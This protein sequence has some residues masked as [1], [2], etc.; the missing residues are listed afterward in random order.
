[1]ALR[2]A[3]YAQRVYDELEATGVL[4]RGMPRPPIFPLVIY[5]GPGTWNIA[6]TLDNFIAAPKP[7]PTATARPEDTADARRAARDLAAF[8]LR[9]AYFTL[10]FGLYREDDPVADNAVSVHIGLD[11]AST[12]D[13]VVRLLN[14][15]P[16]LV[17][18]RLMQT[19]L[20]W[21]L[22]RL[23]MDQ[24]IAEEIMGM[25]NYYS[26]L[27][28]TA[29]AG[30]SS[31]SPKASNT[32]ALK[33]NARCCAGRRSG[34]SARWRRRSILSL[35]RCIPPPSWRRSASGSWQ[36]PSTS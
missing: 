26:Q 34:G 22:L 28:E 24:D 19:M 11:S 13:R 25:A 32:A 30:P 7:P 35:S 36:T 8:Q 3:S 1:M 29:R 12:R 23:G 2:M 33:A 16:E 6:T 5:S 27:E 4:Q 20:Q 21:T 9:H 10:D 18:P 15:L 31:G 17:E 14:L